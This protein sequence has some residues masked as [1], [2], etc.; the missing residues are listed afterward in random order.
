MR[1]KAKFQKGE[2]E[3]IG[4]GFFLPRCRE[5]QRQMQM[6]TNAVRH[7]MGNGKHPHALRTRTCHKAE[8]NH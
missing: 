7:V 1:L 3:V 6:R 8:L 2:H 5:N 4:G